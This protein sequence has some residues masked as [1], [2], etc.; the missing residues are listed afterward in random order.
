MST[1]KIDTAA[2]QKAQQKVNLSYLQKYDAHIVKI[3]ESSNHVALY[4]LNEATQTWARTQTEG[5]LYIVERSVEPRFQLIIYNR[6]SPD[7]KVEDINVD[8]QIQTQESYLFYKNAAGKTYGVWFYNATEREKTVNFL[9]NLLQ[10]LENQVDTAQNQQPG[11][12]SANTDWQP[13][14]A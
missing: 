14:H 7:N 2:Q 11:T 4:D 6:L 10:D 8:F 13:P 5:P 3:L 9:N 12:E 1:T